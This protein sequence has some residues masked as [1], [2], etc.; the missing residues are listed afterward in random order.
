MDDENEILA[1]F[2]FGKEIPQASSP[3]DNNK[4]KLSNS[5]LINNNHAKLNYLNYNKTTKN[6]NLKTEIIDNNNYFENYSA[7]NYN[8]FKGELNE[9]T[10]G[11]NNNL[12]T[13][14]NESNDI[15]IK[16]KEKNK[17][18]M[19][20]NPEGM[21][22]SFIYVIIYSIHHMKLFRQYIIKD[23]NNQMQHTNNVPL[24]FHLREILIQFDKNQIINISKFRNVLSNLFQNYRKFLIG[25]PDDPVDLL[26]VLI[27][28]I[29]SFSIKYPLNEISDE[30]CVEK[31]FSH[32]FIWLD[33]S[34]IDKCKCNGSTKRLFSNHNYITD[35]P[36]NKIFNKIFNLIKIKKNTSLYETKA[37][38][39]EYYTNLVSRMKSN[40]P[41]NGQ[42]CP[43]NITF[44]KLH[45]S[46]SPSYLIFNLEQNFNETNS[47]FAFSAL[48]I[49]KNFILIPN[50][51]DIWKLFEL[52][53]KK[54]KN[55]FDFM[56]C[57][58]FK[59][60]K[61]YSCAFKNKKGILVYYDCNWK[62]DNNNINN[63]NANNIVEFLTFY[64]FVFFCI[65]Y[66]LI[67]IMLFYQGSFLS[68]KNKNNNINKYDASLTKEQINTLEKFCINTDNLYNILQNNLGKKECLIIAKKPKNIILHKNNK[69]NLI[70]NTNNNNKEFL[71]KK[72]IIK[73]MPKYLSSSKESQSLNNS[74]A[75]IDKFKS[76]SLF[77]TKFQKSQDNIKINPEIK[78]KLTMRLKKRKQFYVSPD[79]KH[80]STDKFI[81]NFDFETY[82]EKRDNYLLNFP[83][84]FLQ[85]KNNNNKNKKN[86]L[87]NTEINKTENN[88]FNLNKI[89]I[90]KTIHKSPKIKKTKI[91]H[92][93]SKN[94]DLPSQ[95]GNHK[96]V[97]SSNEKFNY[98]NKDNNY[99]NNIT[100]SNPNIIKSH[101]K[102]SKTFNISKTIVNNEY[103]ENNKINEI[104]INKRKNLNLNNKYDKV[105]DKISKSNKNIPIYTMHYSYNDINIDKIE[106]KK[107]I[108]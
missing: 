35:I 80:K 78:N 5:N 11:V 51:F 48:N 94:F 86:L 61:V 6:K 47:N 9:L 59:I 22:D 103:K 106:K 107:N 14:P 44:H 76:F 21:N 92:K 71:S 68:E 16:S 98:F 69:I 96:N 79:I 54:N 60:T 17:Y 40:C 66:G 75:Y 100:Y 63:N 49:L 84:Q 8:I 3:K 26:F 101:N 62:S 25:Q 74:Q 77:N 85:V 95:K 58:L 102:N 7:Q 42:R 19:L 37:K 45:L 43:I 93:N 64:D 91:I 88:I 65:K 38:L 90:I 31:C 50:Q 83:I 23:L 36:I 70:K 72:I 89:D 104:R 73:N 55:N 18:S 33:L 4:Q 57:V 105:N 13:N 82:P 108:L 30:N 15:N 56:G 52:N 10:F 99:S 41:I 20:I 32:K 24:I 1:S 67:P 29:H 34:R 97:L 87:N 81:E 12:V 39:F 28:A 53:S 2:T 27:N 46:N